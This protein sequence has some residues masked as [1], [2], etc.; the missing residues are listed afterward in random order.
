[1][2]VRT[3]SMRLLLRWRGRRAGCRAPEVGGWRGG[4]RAASGS[5][6]VEAGGVLGHIRAAQRLPPHAVGPGLGAPLEVPV[7]RAGPRSRGRLDR[8][9]RRHVRAPLRSGKR[10]GAPPG[11]GVLRPGRCRRPPMPGRGVEGGGAQR[12]TGASA[13][14]ALLTPSSVPCF[15]ERFRLTTLPLRGDQWIANGEF[16]VIPERGSGGG[17]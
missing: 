11:R 7:A 6:T 15:R 3:G 5:R 17:I 2:T 13:T 14:G 16:R 4:G 10:G 1:M 9:L 8:R 12:S